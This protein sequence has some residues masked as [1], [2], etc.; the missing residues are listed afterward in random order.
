MKEWIE[1]KLKSWGF[2]KEEEVSDYIKEKV[3]EEL[4]AQSES[5]QK[6]IS[7]SEVAL[8]K[9]FQ[10]LTKK[11]E[12]KEI[13]LESQM[14]SILSSATENLSSYTNNKLEEI[15]ER[16]RRET[17][18]LLNKY[19]VSLYTPLNESLTNL[20]K[21][22]NTHITNEKKIIERLEKR[23]KD[24]EEENKRLKNAL[25][26][27]K[28]LTHSIKEEFL[29][30]IRTGQIKAIATKSLEEAQMELN[31]NPKRKVT[32]DELKSFEDK[33]QKVD[34]EVTILQD[35]RESIVPKIEKLTHPVIKRQF[36]Q[37]SIKDLEA[38]KK[39]QK[40]GK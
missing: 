15:K 29:D 11:V 7:A 27:Q 34:E 4:S 40:K 16:E 8:D 25:E 12:D 14:G 30:G 20:I 19:K 10:S 31:K 39:M 9:A 38:L 18:K 2:V 36:S 17:E 22:T 1:K 3:E 33:L 6:Q 13:E 26:S 21:K 32:L 35:F 23:I 24:V 28:N 5:I 37:A